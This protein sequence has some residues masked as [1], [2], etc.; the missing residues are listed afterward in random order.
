MSKP[1][2]ETMR[3]AIVIGALVLLGVGFVSMLPLSEY[4]YIRGAALNQSLLGK[5]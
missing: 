1:F 3:L 2:S 4:R 5:E